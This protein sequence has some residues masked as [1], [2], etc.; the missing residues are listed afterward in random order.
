MKTINNFMMFVVTIILSNLKQ[1][2]YKTFEEN[3]HIR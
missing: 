1:I 2:F 3:L